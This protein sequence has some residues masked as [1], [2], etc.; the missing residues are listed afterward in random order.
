MKLPISKREAQDGHAMCLGVSAKG[1]HGFVRRMAIPERDLVY[2]LATTPEFDKLMRG[3]L[4][5]SVQVNQAA[6]TWH[7]DQGNEGL[8][9]IFAIGDFTG[10]RLLMEDRK[11][12]INGKARLIDGS[13]LHASERVSLA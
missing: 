4:W 1:Q 8:S 12:D 6:S 7:R 2:L 5:T 3:L 9:G 10:G 13:K 11:F